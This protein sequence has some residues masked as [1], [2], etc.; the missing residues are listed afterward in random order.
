MGND[1]HEF[2]DALPKI[3]E[4][5]LGKSFIDLTWLHNENFGSEEWEI[6]K[7]VCTEMYPDEE[8]A[9][10]MMYTLIDVENK[11]SDVNQ[12]KNILDDIN[13]TLAKTFY[14]DEADATEY[15][16]NMMLRKKKM[17]VNIMKSSW[18]INHLNQNLKI[19]RMNNL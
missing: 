4:K 14:K 16:S 19:T 7:R 17:V 9:F 5:V 11:A 1:K 12:R 18:T 8:L 2:D 6:L 10:E 3:Y 15:Y 13:K